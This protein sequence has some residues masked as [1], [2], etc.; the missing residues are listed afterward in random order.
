[1]SFK[2]EISAE[3]GKVAFG[4]SQNAEQK[5]R[6]V[7]AAPPNLINDIVL[8]KAY[9][10]NK[11]FDIVEQLNPLLLP[12]QIKDVL[13]MCE[14]SCINRNK[15]GAGKTVETIEAMRLLGLKKVLVVGPKI[16]K[17]Q[18]AQQLARWY[19]SVSVVEVNSKKAKQMDTHNISIINYE[20]LD[21]TAVEY[22]VHKQ[23]WDAVVFDELTYIANRKAK[24][25][26]RAASIPAQIKWG[27]TGTPLLR[28]IEG[29]W[30][31]LHV[32]LP[33]SVGGSFWGFRGYAANVVDGPF[34]QIVTGIT[35]NA[36]RQ[37][38]LAEMLDRVTVLADT[39]LTTIE[40][41][42][43]T[44]LLEMGSAQ[45]K[46]Y[47][48]IKALEVENLKDLGI[49]IPNGA[50]AALRLRQCC[51]SPKTLG[52]EV[53]GVK[54]EWILEMAKKGEPIFVVSKFE[55]SISNLANFLRSSKID[56]EQLTGKVSSNLR[57][58]GIQR[59][60]DGKVQVMLGTID[61]CAYG[62]D[63]LQKVCRIGVVLDRDWIPEVMQQME[64]RLARTGQQTNI[65]VVWY[66]LE[67]EDTIEQ[68]MSLM[69]SRKL[70]DLEVLLG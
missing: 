65:P 13:K 11:P 45:Q 6:G 17:H 19:P 20:Q 41:I 40:C 70:A 49:K 67:C 69:G 14:G 18:W 26:Q 63:G 60:I 9:T 28:K 39:S 29:L 54:F 30:H 56:S 47:N 55:K 66:Y 2:T 16:I 59:F 48:Q 33:G 21:N 44:V 8:G 31:M 42:Q 68:R 3:L 58:R 61:A 27:L 34:G 24:R 15:M 52:A 38:I 36:N 25:S 4:W 10:P 7:I 5:R 53:D 37:A 23:L 57:D 50:T 43:S 64:A 46:L 22:Y 1:M 35:K 51:S 32:I 12:Y 62:L